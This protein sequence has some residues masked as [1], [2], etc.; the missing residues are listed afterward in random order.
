MIQ[1]MLAINL[2]LAGHMAG[3]GG[4]KKAV[5]FALPAVSG[6]LVSLQSLRG[7]V[8]LLNFWA[9]WCG[10]CREELPELDRI[11]QKYQK[12]G[13]V[14]L[15]VSVDN[16]LENA[17]SFLKKYEI[18]LRALWD[19]QK[20]V[21]AAYDADKMPSSYIVDRKGFVRFVHGGYSDEGLKRIEDE[22]DEL[23]DEP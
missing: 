6:E 11:Q 13:L 2:T 9:T 5:E 12:R 8:V 3:A 22:I 20:K 7:R 15:A 1:W 23:L 14:V 21:I 4:G 17:R 10:P 19:Q 18:R 16:E